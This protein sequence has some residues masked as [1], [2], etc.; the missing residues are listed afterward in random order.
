LFQL[1]RGC[2][3]HESNIAAS[4]ILPE[5]LEALRFGFASSYSC[6]VIHVLLAGIILDL[7]TGWLAKYFDTGQ[8]H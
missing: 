5:E 1:Q 4:T 7:S 2:A 8:K 3:S 6:Q